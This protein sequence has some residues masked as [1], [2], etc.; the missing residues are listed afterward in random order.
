MPS[1]PLSPNR[2]FFNYY[3]IH[4][5]LR[6]SQPFGMRVIYFEARSHN[7]IMDKEEVDRVEYRT[8]DQA[9]Q[10]G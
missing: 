7:C 2:C 10:E 3:S 1:S 5:S 4:A 6:Q 9:L 8:T